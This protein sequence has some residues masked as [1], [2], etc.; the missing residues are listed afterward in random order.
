MGERALRPYLH[1]DSGSSVAPG[2]GNRPGRRLPPPSLPIDRCR[3]GR[4]EPT[5]I[6]ARN[7]NRRWPE[8]DDAPPSASPLF[9]LL[10]GVTGPATRGL[11]AS[12]AQRTAIPTPPALPAPEKAP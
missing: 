6:T 10:P 12:G 8:A 3:R 4:T 11:T 1:L 2:A 7:N 5:N 9:P